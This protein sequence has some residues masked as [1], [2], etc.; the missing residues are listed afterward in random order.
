MRSCARWIWL[1]AAYTHAEAARLCGVTEYAIRWA[2][3]DG[4]LKAM[5][6][7][8]IG[9]LALFVALKCRRLH[10]VET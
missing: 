2:V 4:R 9:G 1:D 10:R 5:P 6:D 7:G 8:R 3:T